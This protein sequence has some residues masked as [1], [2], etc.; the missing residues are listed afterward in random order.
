MLH[1]MKCPVC[2][3]ALEEVSALCPGCGS[4]L[5]ATAWQ[6]GEGRGPPRRAAGG[7][8]AAWGKDPLGT[9]ATQPVSVGGGAG[10]APPERR[11]APPAPPREKVAARVLVSS[12]LADPIRLDE[13]KVF[14]IGRDRT[15]DVCFPSTHVSRTHAE[16]FHERGQWVLEDRG[17]RNGTQVNGERVLKRPLRHGDRVSV[18]QFEVSFMELT[19]EELE[20]LRGKKRDVNSDTLKLTQDEIGFFGD[21][22]RLSVVEVVQLL[23]QNR[24]TG[25]LSVHEEKAPERKLTL[26]DGAIVHAEFGS[27]KGEKAVLP[28]LRARAG[29]FAF[30]PAAEGEEEPKV[31][32]ETP[33]PVLLLQALEGMK[34]K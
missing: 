1:G 15:C 9:R 22:K 10:A 7:V 34:P 26:K 23:G 14:R 30:R 29:R 32:I 27:M 20:E 33:T 18:G 13:S 12:V 19:A 4:A 16:I 6:P 2:G 3:L 5:E 24:K 31:T 17:S 25:V 11:E 21:V 8:T 28:I